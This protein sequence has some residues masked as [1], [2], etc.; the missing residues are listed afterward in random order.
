MSLKRF[1][2]LYK[3]TNQRILQTSEKDRGVVPHIFQCQNWLGGLCLR[4]AIL[5][6]YMQRSKL[7]CQQFVVEDLRRICLFK[8]QFKIVTCII[9]QD[10]NLCTQSVDLIATG[11]V[12]DTDLEP[13][14]AAGNT[15]RCLHVHLLLPSE[16][17]PTDQNLVKSLLEM[18]AEP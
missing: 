11:K 12:I 14:D 17:L 5:A 3:R 13:V 4:V 16:I 2:G 10:R 18:D 6:V 1:L 9:N 15:L 8:M 7:E